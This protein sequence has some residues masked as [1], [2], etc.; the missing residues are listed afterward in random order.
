MTKVFFK[1]ACILD[2]KD[3]LGMTTPVDVL[4]E[5]GKIK[6][7]AAKLEACKNFATIDAEDKLLMPGLVNGHFHYSVNHMK[8]ALPS[9]PREIFMLYESLEFD[10]LRPTPRQAYFRTM[11]GCI[12]MLKSVMT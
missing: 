3:S 7:I 11:F 9:L 12:E 4:V 10:V 5:G 6:R 1:K 8:G 2:L